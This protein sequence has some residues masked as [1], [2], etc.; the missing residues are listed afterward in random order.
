MGAWRAA[1][2]PEGGSFRLFETG[3]I[4][5][6]A[7]HWSATRLVRHTRAGQIDR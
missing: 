3:M 6:R 5:L 7:Q 1:G 2:G 4:R